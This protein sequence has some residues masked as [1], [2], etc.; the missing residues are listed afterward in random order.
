MRNILTIARK[1]LTLYFTTPWAWLV[2]AAMALL[3]SFFFMQILG[4]FKQVHEL[5]QA[6]T[7][8]KAPPDW[9][10]FKNLT[11]G[12]VV[13]LWGVVIIVTLFAGPI[14]SMRL[15]SDPIYLR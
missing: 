2:F 15:F 4:T 11:D 14:L 9:A 7:W 13:Q 3:S 5:A 1:E 6:F 8:A 10:P 12:V